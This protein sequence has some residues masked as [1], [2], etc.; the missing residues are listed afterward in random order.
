MLLVTADDRA[1]R[2]NP[3]ERP[4]TFMFDEEAQQGA[5]SHEAEPD[6]LARGLH[7]AR[8]CLK[9]RGLRDD[10]F[11]PGLFSDPA[12]DILLDLYIAEAKDEHVQITSLAIAARVP[13]STAIRWAG[14]MTRSGLLERQKDP[15]DARRIHISLSPRARVLLQ[16][17]LEKLSRDGQA[18]IPI[19]ARQSP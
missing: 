11:G 17:Y 4:P 1:G 19:L 18:P 16:E 3:D 13:H 5:L 14:N 15:R 10:M 7:I 9:A 6:H 2:G 12:W 8:W